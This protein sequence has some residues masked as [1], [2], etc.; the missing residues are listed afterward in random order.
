MLQNTNF[1]KRLVARH[2]GPPVKTQRPIW[3]K[4]RLREI[5]DH[6]TK[7]N[8]GKRLVARHR[9]PPVMVEDHFGQKV[10][11]ARDCGP[12]EMAHSP[13]WA[14]GRSHERLQ[15]TGNG[16]KANFGKR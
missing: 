15:T 7:A 4:G 1:G 5:A 14:M 13:F 2:R 8:L 16:S 12:E 9:G 6:R 10:G 11:H 3:A